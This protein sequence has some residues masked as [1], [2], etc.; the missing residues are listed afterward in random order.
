MLALDMKCTLAIGSPRLCRTYSMG[1]NRLLLVINQGRIRY[2]SL[3]H[4]E[5][6]EKRIYLRI[7]TS[8]T[9]Q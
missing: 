5:L 8:L 3:L 4:L 9:A 7:P 2:S 6:K 1:M